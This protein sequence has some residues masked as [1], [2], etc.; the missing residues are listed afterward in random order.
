MPSDQN[1]NGLAAYQRFLDAQRFCTCGHSKDDH[2]SGECGGWN[3]G[4]KYMPESPRWECL[5]PAFTPKEPAHE[6][7]Q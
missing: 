3:Y 1:T 6:H 2:E 5:C 7:H 4:A